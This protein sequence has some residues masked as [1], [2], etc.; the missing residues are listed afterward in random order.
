MWKQQW[1]GYLI[2]LIHDMPA[3]EMEVL[4]ED[5]DSDGEGCESNVELED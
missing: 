5:S 4:S 2:L 3:E 1:T